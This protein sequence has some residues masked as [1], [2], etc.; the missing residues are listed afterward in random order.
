MSRWVERLEPAAGEALRLAARCQHLM[1]WKQPRSDFPPGR[2]GYHAWRKHMAA[3]HADE[4]EGV[5]RGIGY[6]EATIGEVRRIVLK[7]GM[8]THADVQ[9]MEDALCLAFIEY[10]L[11]AFAE[12]L[13]EDK[14]VDILRQTWR[15]MSPRGHAHAEAL[16]PSLPRRVQE[17]IGAALGGTG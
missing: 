10:E 15:K 8:A 16:L 12:G 1:R 7:Q 9:T 4:A 17:L 6:D 14:L 13:T 5:L 3:F 11:A 2:A